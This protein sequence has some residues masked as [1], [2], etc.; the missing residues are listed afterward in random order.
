MKSIPYNGDKSTLLKYTDFMEQRLHN[1]SMFR[2]IAWLFIA[3]HATLLVLSSRLAPFPVFYAQN[4]FGILYFLT[5]LFINRHH[6]ISLDNSIFMTVIGIW[7][8]VFI[9]FL[10]VGIKAGFQVYCFATLSASFF[11]MN[12][13]DSRKWQSV[14]PRI[15][16][17][18][19]A[20]LCLGM[21]ILSRFMQ[22]VYAL[23]APILRAISFCNALFALLELL[24]FSDVYRMRMNRSVTRLEQEADLDE[25][26]GLLNRHGIRRIFE[27]CNQLWHNNATP[28]AVAIFD[29]DDFKQVN[30][31]YGHAMG[32]EVLQVVA[33][34]LKFFCTEK[35]SPCRWGGEEFLVIGQI[36]YDLALFF[37]HVEMVAE[38]ISQHEFTTPNG[39][40]FVTVTCG[41]AVIEN[42]MP[43]HELI[44]KADHRLY[45]GKAA[46][47]NQVRVF[48]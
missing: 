27:V 22:P 45:A 12:S 25:L 36:R 31:T 35:S 28:Y 3:G 10:I 46:G 18:G 33:D 21:L 5:L 41:V 26:T 29:I 42:D 19:S 1:L 17:I 24:I 37:Q 7:I 43:V 40:F 9:A 32:D 48:D 39:S 34:E 15:V 20:T 47:K 14:Q 44:D 6:W 30:D 4:V 8:Q 13:S 2:L 16:E 38:R 23:K 11:I